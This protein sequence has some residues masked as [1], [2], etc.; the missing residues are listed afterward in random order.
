[1]TVFE[2]TDQESIQKIANKFP[3]KLIIIDFWTPWCEPCMELKP[4]YTELSDKFTEQIFLAV[5][6][7]NNDSIQ[8]IYN[9]ESIPFLVFIK[10][11]CVIDYM[12]GTDINELINKI[13]I[14]TSH[15]ESESVV[16]Q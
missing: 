4:Q 3:Q 10:N 14:H 15:S 11:N 2:L 8:K 13:N 6:I 5:N 9:I 1:M 12:M 7:D 16:S